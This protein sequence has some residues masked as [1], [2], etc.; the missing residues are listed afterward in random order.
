[1]P[2]RFILL[3]LVALVS[4]VRFAEAQPPSPLDPTLFAFPGGSMNPPSAAN[5]GLAGADQRRGVA[6][7]GS[8]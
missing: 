1:M 5:A 8:L 3:L 4:A 2:S 6:G 7:G